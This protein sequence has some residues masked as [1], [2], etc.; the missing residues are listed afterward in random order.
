MDQGAQQKV[1]LLRPGVKRLSRELKQ[2]E[3]EYK[4]RP[5]KLREFLLNLIQLQKRLMMMK[6]NVSF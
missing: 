6:K 3:L 4:L 2:E 1:V 5:Q